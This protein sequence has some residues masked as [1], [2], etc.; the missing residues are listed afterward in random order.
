MTSYKISDP[1]RW[2]RRK[3]RDH[4]HITHACVFD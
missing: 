4:I 2:P 3:R 1:S